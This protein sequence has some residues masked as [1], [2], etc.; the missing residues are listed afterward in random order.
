MPVADRHRDI[1][2]RVIGRR[3]C[4]GDGAGAL[5]RGNPPARRYAP[6]KC[7]C[8]A[9]RVIC[10]DGCRHHAARPYGNGRST[11]TIDDRRAVA[12]GANG[13]WNQHIPAICIRYLDG[14]CAACC[15]GR[16]RLNG[17]RRCAA[18]A[19]DRPSVVGRPRVGERK[20]L[21]TVCRHG[22]RYRTTWCRRQPLNGQTLNHRGRTLDNG[23]TGTS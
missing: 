23:C 15:V 20:T 16:G 10:G 22:R 1:P 3:C 11:H 12:D 4:Y 18:P 5:A 19:Y 8:V 13:Y 7:E 9:I 17:C 2:T 6:G 21:C 14:H